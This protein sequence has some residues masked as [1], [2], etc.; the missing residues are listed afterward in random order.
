MMVR[1]A[2]GQEPLFYGFTI[3]RHV[4][5]DRLL[6]AIDR[7]VDLEGVREHLQ[8]FYSATGRPTDGPEL[9][10]LMLIVGYCVFVRPGPPS[11]RADREAALVRWWIVAG[12]ARSDE[13]CAL[14]DLPTVA[15][16]VGGLL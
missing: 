7:F 5:A 10:L 2:V 14:H 3:E 8:P 12:A 1:Q 4:P 6:R 9:L 16:W 11:F 13:L 15:S